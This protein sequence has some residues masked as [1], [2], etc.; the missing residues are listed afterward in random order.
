MEK[1]KWPVLEG[2]GGFTKA[3]NDA[4]QAAYD[5]GRAEAKAETLKLLDAVEQHYIAKHN[6]DSSLHNYTAQEVAGACVE[7][8]QRGEVVTP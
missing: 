7:T 6:D 4:I 1:L 2:D 3:I 8:V 5:L